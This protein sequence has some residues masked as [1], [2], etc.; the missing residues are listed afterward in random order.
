MSASFWLQMVVE[1]KLAL[2]GCMVTCVRSVL[3]SNF[4]FQLKCARGSGVIADLSH[5]VTDSTSFP[6]CEPVVHM[7]EGWMAKN[8]LP[9][10]ME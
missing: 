10:K 9:I 6:E 1:Q 3:Y 5:L 4:N 7:D 2:H 8:V